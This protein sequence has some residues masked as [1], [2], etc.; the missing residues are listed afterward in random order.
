MV[1]G[2]AP[3]FVG[4][5]RK[6]VTLLFTDIVGSTALAERLDPEEWG[7]V[8]SGAHR[9]VTE[10]IHSRGGTVAQ[11]LGDGVLAFFG[12]PITHEDDPVRAVSASLA[13]LSSI[14]TYAQELASR[15]RI[16]NF[17]MRVGLNT[18]LVVVGNVGSAGH[19]EYLAVGD[20]V[21]LAAR[22]QSAASPNSVLISESTARLV[23]H[24]FELESV[25]PLDLKGKSEPISAFRVVV[26]KS[27]QESGRGIEGLSSPLVGRDQELAQLR[28]SLGDVGR[29]RGRV[30][31]LMGEAG[32]GKSRLLTELKHVAMRGDAEAGAGQARPITWIEGRCLSDES[33]IPYALITSALR[34][35]LGDAASAHQINADRY[36]S[37]TERVGQV[38]GDR[39][40][41]VAPLLATLLGIT[42][43]GEAAERVR[44]L[45]PPMLRGRIFGAV[46]EFVRELAKIQPTILVL[47][48]LHW[49][50]STSLDLIEQLLPLTERGMLM[51]LAAFRPQRQE[52][53]WR[54]YEVA[55]RD[56]SHRH[57]AIALEPLDEAESRSMVANLLH[58]EDLPESVRALILRK[59]E[60]NP[61]FIEEL[62][63]SLL[64]SKLVVRDNGH[65]RATRAIADIA[66]PDTLGEVIGAR[67]DR[68]DASAKRVVQTAAVIGREFPLGLLATVYGTGDSLEDS[69]VDLQRRELI[70]ESTRLPEVVF[71]FKHALTQET[72]YSSLLLSRRRELHGRIAHALEQH[73]PSRVHDIAR[74]FLDARD[75]R[76]AL[77]YLVDAAD[78]SARAYATSTAIDLYGQALEILKTVDDL[79]LARRAYEGLGGAL[80][81]ASDLPRAMDTYHTMLHFA[82]GHGDGPMRVS[83]LNKLAMA[84]MYLGR[85]PEIEEHLL[86][87]ERLAR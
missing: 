17:Q 31:S 84:M 22:L 83:A 74:H 52:P 80:A 53:S 73:D 28:A 33:A 59:A 25:G 16:E 82:E 58:I 10:A 11:L 75:E 40:D 29:G 39:V 63:R 47:E 23:R 54:F 38:V 3:S 79:A 64:D 78:R 18:G 24:A 32:L 19:M 70:Q 13:I 1:A 41:D 57:T 45:E 77:P 27:V 61:F 43:T 12:A 34:Y 65:W 9:C 85:F 67:V 48:D 14:G 20:S 5:E 7:E 56:Y 36:A 71:V 72:A 46:G 76:R 50:D 87:A 55:Q 68:L 6:L 49:T 8:V 86:D 81:L 62:I 15:Q 26:R 44:Y 2:A 21:N 60:G 69:L 42:L 66:I 51:I 35:W 4:G 37:L 30:V